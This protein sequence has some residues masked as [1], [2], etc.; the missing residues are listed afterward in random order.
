MPDRPAASGHTLS[1]LHLF[2][3]CRACLCAQ[4]D[5]IVSEYKAPRSP[6]QYLVKWC[7]LEYSE[8]TWETQEEICRDGAGQVSV[9]PVSGC[10]A[11]L[12]HPLYSSS[13]RAQ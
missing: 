6:T 8:C 7:G 2:A 12:T 11:V 10:V 1:V 13:W 5:R 3:R 4:I 9:H